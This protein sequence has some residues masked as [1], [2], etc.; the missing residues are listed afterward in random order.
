MNRFY[1]CAFLALAMATLTACQDIDFFGKSDDAKTVVVESTPKASPTVAVTPVKGPVY[2]FTA[3]PRESFEKGMQD[4]G[5]IAA[6]LSRMTGA[7]IQYVHQ[8]DW[9]SYIRSIS[10]KEYDIYFDG[11]HFNV[12]RNRH[13]GHVALARIDTPCSQKERAANTCKP[14]KPKWMLV[15]RHDTEVKRL[16]GR[17]F[18]LHAPPNFGTL[19][20]L[21]SLFPNPAQQPSVREMKG[22]EN[23]VRAVAVKQ[24]GCEFTVARL[25]H[26]KKVDPTGKTLVTKPF[27]AFVQQGFTAGSNLPPDMIAK[28]RAA[29]VAEEGRKAMAAFYERF[30]PKGKAL[31]TYVDS[32]EYDKPLD[33]LV[34]GYLVPWRFYAE[35]AA[36][37]VAK[38]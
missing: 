28:M 20:L 5:P 3:P 35:P 37:S 38:H 11:P 21:Y 33:I 7:N 31:Q 18:C 32:P 14:F 22:W 2:R 34:K 27:D 15:Y 24:N 8:T 13:L 29:L 16:Y 1:Q 9:M 6:Y 4:Y 19:S 30:V 12:W 23:M 25:K 17:T 36:D 26:A 10:K